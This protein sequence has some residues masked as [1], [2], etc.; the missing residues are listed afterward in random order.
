MTRNARTALG[1]GVL[2]AVLAA[3][4]LSKW[5]ILRVLHLP[6]RGVV[7][8]L[9][10]LSLTMVWNH[11]VTFGMLNGGGAGPV[12][13]GVVAL[14]IVGGLFVWMRRAENALVAAALGGIAGGAVGNV[15]D[16]A[17]Y[18]AVVDFLHLHA[19][20]WDPFP[21]V[22]NVGDAA[23]C[24]GVAALVIEGLLPRR[25]HDRLAGA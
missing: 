13:L 1:L 8:V 11:G 22:F 6:D 14:A 4:Q 10:V 20:G 15:I 25:P 23:I 24:V 16:R 12:L 2:L 17:R 21:Y 18:G 7:A 9:P 5:W 19:G 3:D